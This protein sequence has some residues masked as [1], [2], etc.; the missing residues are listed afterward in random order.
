MEIPE[1]FEQ[2]YPEDYVWMLLWT[3][4][5]LKQAT[6]AF[7]KQL[8]MALAS[9]KYARGKADPC[10]YFDWNV[11]GL[12]VWISWVDDCLV[13]GK[14]TGVLTAK[15]QMTDRFECDEIGNMEDYV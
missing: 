10:M 15:K 9:M 12:I 7:W 4:Y 11:N 2:Y 5:G 8:I 3:I 1:G 14:E 6:V 13:C